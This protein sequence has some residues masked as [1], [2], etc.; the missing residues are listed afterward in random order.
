[1]AVGSDGSVYF[2][3]RKSQE[4]HIARVASDRR[5]KILPFETIANRLAIRAN[6]LWLMTSSSQGID[7]ERVDLSN[8]SRVTYFGW[9][10]RLGEQPISLD[11]SGKVLPKD[12]QRRLEGHWANSTFGLRNDGVPIIV[13]GEGRL[14]EAVGEGRLRSWQPHGYASA[15]ERIT[16]EQDLEPYAVSLNTEDDSL[17]I[18]GRKGVLSVPLNGL[19]TSIAFPKSIPAAKSW[20][21]AVSLA[22]GSVLLLGGNKSFPQRPNPTRLSPNG[23]LSAL[24]WGN[25]TDCDNFD[26][27]LAVIGS[28]YPGSVARRPDGSL[29]MNDNRCGRVYAFKMPK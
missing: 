19:S 17:T 26:G 8:Y 9:K 15:L 27:S 14:F 16:G 22:D 5:L 12:E 20:T 28:A 6:I 1:L 21:A 3:V 2:P 4:S 10:S 13:S 11:P 29:V 7:L 18:L 23:K 25:W 24:S